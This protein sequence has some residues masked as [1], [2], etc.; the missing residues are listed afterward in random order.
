[1][2]KLI[3]GIL[4]TIVI[5]S[6]YGLPNRPAPQT[7]YPYFSFAPQPPHLQEQREDTQIITH[8][9]TTIRQNLH[10]HVLEQPL[11]IIHGKSLNRPYTMLYHNQTMPPKPPPTTS[12]P[13]NSNLKHKLALWLPLGI[14]GVIGI[15]LAFIFRKKINH[16]V[17]GIPYEA[18]HNAYVT[19]VPEDPNPGQA[20]GHLFTAHTYQQATHLLTR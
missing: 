10:F 7:H 19:I 17:N 9:I 3:L 2:I 6:V 13:H 5:N 1:M 16:L 18:F 12:T 20:N 15:T 14:S 4:C 8:L 11:T